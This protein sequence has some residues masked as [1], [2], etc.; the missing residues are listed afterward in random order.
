MATS[1]PGVTATKTFER[2]ITA[3]QRAMQLQRLQGIS[4]ARGFK[5][6]SRTQPRTQKQ[7]I[8]FDTANQK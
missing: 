1:A 8:G 4:R 5:T 7:P 3:L 2:E 6:A